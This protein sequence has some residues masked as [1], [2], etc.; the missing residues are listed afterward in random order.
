M[1]Y[2]LFPTFASYFTMEKS[3]NINDIHDGKYAQTNNIA[4]IY[5]IATSNVE[6]D[7]VMFY[8]LSPTY[9]CLRD[10]TQWKTM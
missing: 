10:E 4:N 9:L 3:Y 5:V 7:L 2:H 1:L 6:N 8:Y